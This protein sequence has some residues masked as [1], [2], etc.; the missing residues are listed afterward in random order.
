MTALHFARSHAVVLNE[1]Q[2][3]NADIDADIMSASMKDQYFGDV[4][5]LQLRFTLQLRK[6]AR[7][8]K[9]QGSSFEADSRP[10][11]SELFDQHRCTVQD[12]AR[13]TSESLQ[14]T[15]RALTSWVVIPADHFPSRAHVICPALF[16]I[17]LHKTVVQ[18]MY[19][20]YAKS[21]QP[22]FEPK[23]RL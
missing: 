16:S 19:L 14:P 13:W 18:E 1:F 20:H 8:W 4:D 10:I 17:L 21:L 6:L 12:Q 2:R 7:R 3:I 9:V 23:S 5:K 15:A 11:L 22:P